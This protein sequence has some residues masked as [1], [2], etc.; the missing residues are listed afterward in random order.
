MTRHVAD[1]DHVV[2][3]QGVLHS[4]H[5]LLHVRVGPVVLRTA[6]AVADVGHSARGVAG[7]RKHA[8]GEWTI[9]VVLRGVPVGCCAYP[10]RALPIT[11]VRSP[12]HKRWHEV[13]AE[14]GP[15]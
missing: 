1:I 3:G 15:D 8:I 6:R 10:G 2:L 5:P 14:S 13:D 11:L 9:E 4:G 7:L 12:S